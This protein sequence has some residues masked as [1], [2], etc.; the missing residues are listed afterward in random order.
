[1]IRSL[2]VAFLL[3]AACAPDPFRAVEDA[4]L[5]D[6]T[7][8]GHRADEGCEATTSATSAWGRMEFE[9]VYPDGLYLQA[10]GCDGGDCDELPWLIIPL[11]EASETE[12]TGLAISSI[13]T[14]GG[15]AGGLGTCTAAW[16]E[17]HAVQKGGRATLELVRYVEDVP[18]VD[19]DDCATYATSAAGETCGDALA[20]DLTR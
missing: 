8:T 13:F 14:G 1:M 4:W 5:G 2:P 6:W 3:L 9:F 10:R 19:Y 11:E 20:Y 17:V 7:V 16:A 12:L 18:A 15:P